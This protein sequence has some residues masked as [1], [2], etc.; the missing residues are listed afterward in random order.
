MAL[1]YTRNDQ[2]YTAVL[3][4]CANAGAVYELMVQTFVPRPIAWVLTENEDGSHNLA[5]YSFT[6]L[7][8][9]APPTIVFSAGKKSPSVPKDSWANIVRTGKA[10]VHIPSAANAAAV[11][12]S[13]AALPTGA[14]EVDTYHIKTTPFEGFPLPR[15]SDAPVAYG[16][17]LKEVVELGTLPVGLIVLEVTHLFVDGKAVEHVDGD[18]FHINEKVINPLT[19]MGKTK[20]GTL[21]PILDIGSPPKIA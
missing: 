8:D 2:G 5:P 11:N 13:A 20:F 14:S 4:G 1:T 3:E 21:G 18:I 19:R 10:V 15:V 6:A 16:C 12:N 17:K 9:I 7:V